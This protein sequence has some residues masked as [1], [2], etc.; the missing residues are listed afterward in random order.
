MAKKMTCAWWAGKDEEN[1][2]YSS[3]QMP[4]LVY[5]SDIPEQGVV[6][7]FDK[8]G[9]SDSQ[10]EA[11]EK[12][13]LVQFSDFT[14][15]PAKKL[16]RLK[17]IKILNHQKIQIENFNGIEQ[18]PQLE[19][20]EIDAAGDSPLD[21]S[22]LGAVRSL[23]ILKIPYCP[24]A[25]PRQLSILKGLTQLDVAG[26]GLKDLSSIA[27]LDKLEELRLDENK[28][29]S[30]APLKELKNL[31]RLNLDETR[32]NDLTALSSLAKIEKLSAADNQISDISSLAQ[33][34]SLS[35]LNLF[36]NKITDVNALVD[37]KNLRVLNLSQNHVHGVASLKQPS[38]K[39][40]W[41]G[42]KI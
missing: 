40:Y 24:L 11:I 29:A 7:P 2:F 39:I 14:M 38:I 4:A 19:F 35:D 25:D 23:K 22:S 21:I 20:L 37:L 33:L 6:S 32:I 16:I 1:G 18:L 30:L 3:F 10:L 42:Q 34:K 41:D 36:K 31:R 5:G 17:E 27:A 9:P 28:I 8:S 12:M 13:V 26:C 15:L